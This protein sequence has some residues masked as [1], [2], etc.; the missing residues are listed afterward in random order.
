[1]GKFHYNAPR[2]D[3]PNWR[4]CLG[5]GCTTRVY[6]R[7]GEYC[8]RHAEV[9]ERRCLD[10]GRASRPGTLGYVEPQTA[11]WAQYRET[12]GF[13]REWAPKA[14]KQPASRP[15][16]REYVVAAGVC[17]HC[18][19]ANLAKLEFGFD[20]LPE[21]QQKCPAWTDTRP[22]AGDGG[23]P[24]AL[25]NKSMGDPGITWKTC[26]SC[27]ERLYPDFRAGVSSHW[28]AKRSLPPTRDMRIALPDGR[29]S[30]DPT[31]KVH[32]DCP[33]IEVEKAA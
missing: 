29:W 9:P 27:G 30:Y 26:A 31:R 22:S 16:T 21:S 18:G 19:S 4:E 11:T 20:R 33:D 12:T 7:D 25:L 3:D 32:Y 15:V 24:N 5:N 10:C 2:G 8:Y 1:M 13:E 6:W 17:C 23:P 28:N 14:L